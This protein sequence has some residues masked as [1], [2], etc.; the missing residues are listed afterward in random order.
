METKAPRRFDEQETAR[1]LEEASRLDVDEAFDEPRAL[2][3][4]AER[5][6][7][8]GLTLAE[9]QSIGEEAGI[10]AA[11]VARAAGAIIAFLSDG[12]CGDCLSASHEPSSSIVA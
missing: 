8:N 1:I 5:R 10:S 12:P 3:G 11:A 4:P 7:A 6:A 2:S 9:L